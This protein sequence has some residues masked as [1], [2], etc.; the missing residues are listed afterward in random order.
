M[1]TP[2]EIIDMVASLQNDTAQTT[3]TDA[4]CLP[5]LNMALDEL[6]EVFEINNIPVTN[7]VSAILMVPAGNTEI[8]FAGTTPLLPSNLIE[9]QELWERPRGTDPFVSMARLEFLPHYMEGVTYTSFMFW[10]WVDNAINVL[11]SNQDN[12]LKLDY[13][14]SIF[15]TPL[16]INQVNTDLGVKFKN[17]KSY[18]GYKTAAL[19]S[20]YIGENETRAMA[21]NAQAED[22]LFRS[23]DISIK[24]KQS[25]M[26]RRRPFRAG[27]KSRIT[28]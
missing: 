3:Y 18:L 11:A 7:V 2:A 12:D 4:A 25:I 26:N 28:V 19:C 23:L 15:P 14:K 8:A 16:N 9:I 22:A 17:I 1:P 20:M 5:Y 6:Q 24:G 21:L 10:A 13:I 27:Y